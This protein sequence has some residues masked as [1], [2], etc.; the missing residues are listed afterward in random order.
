MATLRALSAGRN[1]TQHPALSTA[2]MIRL[3]CTKCSA[4]LSI[5]DAFAGGVCRC[6]HCGT[7]QTVPKRMK[8]SADAADA[9][10]AVFEKPKGQPPKPERADIGV[11]SGLDELAQIVASSGLGA[12]SSRPYARSSKRTATA[13][14]PLPTAT[15]VVEA[16]P[17]AAPPKSR[18]PL[19]LIAAAILII[20]LLGT[21]IGILLKGQAAPESRT[22]STAQ[23]FGVTLDEPTVIFVLDRGNA[24]GPTLDAVKATCLRTLEHFTPDQKVQVIFWHRNGDSDPI[25]VPSSPT[26]ATDKTRQ[27]IRR[28]MDEVTAKGQ[29]DSAPALKRAFTSQPDVVIIVTPKPVDSDFTRDVIAARGPSG[30]KIHCF[31]LDEPRSLPAMQT[32]ATQTG[33]TAKVVSADQIHP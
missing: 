25:A 8:G 2:P 1:L 17:G 7:I 26:S 21:V 18:F 24:S 30:A 16:P 4:E 3:I 9:P 11:S 32:I 13:P 6:Q 15:K 28:V 5:D 23:F 12:S 33:G 29:S 19:I 20:L 27:D 10:K 22:T 31:A 14:A